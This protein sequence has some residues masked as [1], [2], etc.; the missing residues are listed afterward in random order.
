MFA[1]KFQ[2]DLDFG[3]F[4]L[5]H[6]FVGWFRHCCHW[7]SVALLYFKLVRFRQMVFILHLFFILKVE[8]FILIK[9]FSF[10]FLKE[11]RE[12]RN[13]PKGLQQ[14]GLLLVSLH[15]TLCS[16]LAIASKQIQIV[17]LECF[18]CLARFSLD[19]KHFQQFVPRLH[20]HTQ[21]GLVARIETSRHHQTSVGCWTQNDQRRHQQ[22]KEKLNQFSLS[23]SSAHFLKIN[24]YP[25]NLY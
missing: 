17:L 23:F 1:N 16:L 19:R 15:W 7:I 25:N 20:C 10:F 18:G 9:L 21:V 14:F 4:F 24:S 22:G 6:H 11:R 12:W 3:R 5:D 8:L 2:F 13:L